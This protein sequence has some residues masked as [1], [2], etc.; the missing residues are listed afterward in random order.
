MPV[1]QQGCRGRGARQWAHRARELAAYKNDPYL[2]GYYTDN[3]LPTPLDALDRYL[4][5]DTSDPGFRAVRAWFTERRGETAD[6]GDIT[7]TDRREFLRFFAQT[8]YRTVYEAV[9]KYDPN[10]MVLGSRINFLELPVQFFQGAGPYVDAMSINYYNTWTPQ[11]RILAKI[12]GGCGKPV[13]LTEWYVKGDDLGFPNTTG[14]GWIVPTQRDRG[15]FYQHFALALLGSKVC[16]GWQWF[17]YMDNDTSDLD[18]ELSN[19]DSNK[20]MVSTTFEPHTALIEEM[21]KL[22]RCVFSVIDYLDGAVGGVEARP[23]KAV[24]ESASG[25]HRGAAPP[26]GSGDANEVTKGLHGASL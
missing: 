1:H 20:G 23:A 18:A 21:R 9:K 16:V 19:R 11:P 25:T 3:E 12:A 2:I 8:F 22:N 17:K 5:L 15:Y 24:T 13:L 26:H 7:D 6:A 4:S 14:A 10:H